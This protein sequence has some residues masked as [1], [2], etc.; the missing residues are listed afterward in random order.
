MSNFQKL[1]WIFDQ[2]LQFLVLY[3]GINSDMERIFIKLSQSPSVDIIDLKID[4]IHPNISPTQS[5]AQDQFCV[6]ERHH[7]GRECDPN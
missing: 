2:L 6:P 1:C 7:Y 5:M 4:L 3:S